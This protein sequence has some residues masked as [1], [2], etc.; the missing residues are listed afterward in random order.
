MFF[1]F[2]ESKIGLWQNFPKVYL[3]TLKFYCLSSLMVC[4]Y[5]SLRLPQKE[6][7]VLTKLSVGEGQRSF[8]KSGKGAKHCTLGTPPFVKCWDRVLASINIISIVPYHPYI[9]GMKRFTQ[10]FF[11]FQNNKISPQF[12]RITKPTSQIM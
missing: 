7:T 12:N 2:P 11:I 10:T 3:I 9:V 1:D 8:A 5:P 4:H 6:G